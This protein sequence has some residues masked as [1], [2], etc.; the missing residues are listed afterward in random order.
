MAAADKP[1]LKFN[2]DAKDAKAK[3]GSLPRLR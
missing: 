2:W 1:E 3:Y